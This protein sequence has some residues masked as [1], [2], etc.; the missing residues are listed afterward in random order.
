MDARFLLIVSGILIGFL[1][2]AMLVTL[3]VKRNVKKGIRK[4]REMSIGS[5]TIFSVESSIAE[6]PA[7]VQRYLRKALS[8]NQRM[9]HFVKLKQIGEYRTSLDGDWSPMRADAHYLATRPGFIWKAR[10]GGGIIPSKIAWLELLEGK[11]FGSV[12]FLGLFTLLNPSGYEADT[13]LLARYLTEAIWFPTALLPA[14]LLSWKAIDD[15]SAEATVHYGSNH[16]SA[17]FVFDEHDDVK[18]ITTEDKYRDFRS[19]F[20][21]ERFTLLCNNYQSFQGIR[22]PTEV[23]FVWNLKDGDFCY[24]KYK[25]TSMHYEF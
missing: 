17:V 19:S 10:F 13:S 6:C 12:K 14:S 16:I 8:N 21:K 11:G 18:Y 23:D 7:P 1:F 15:H 3:E 5:P 9:I 4:L 22:I 24:G 20:Q 25:I 2:L